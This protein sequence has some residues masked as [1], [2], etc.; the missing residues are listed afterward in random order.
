M[1]QQ[2]I[3]QVNLNNRNEDNKSNKSNKQ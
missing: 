2:T 1:A 3:Y